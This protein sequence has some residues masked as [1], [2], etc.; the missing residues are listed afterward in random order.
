MTRLASLAIVVGTLA[1]IALY[2]RPCSSSR[3]DVAQEEAS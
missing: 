2:V 3:A 1:F